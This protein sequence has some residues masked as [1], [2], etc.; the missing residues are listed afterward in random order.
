MKIIG[1]GIS[2]IL[3]V[4]CLSI[5]TGC[6]DDEGLPYQ[7]E[8]LDPVIDL[9]NPSS[10]S[11]T[12]I[13]VTLFD[14]KGNPM[15]GGSMSFSLSSNAS[16]YLWDEKN[17]K[18]VK[19]LSV[20][21]SKGDIPEVWYQATNKPETVVV[22]AYCPGYPHDTVV[23]TTIR[24]VNGTFN[25]DFSYY[26][27][28]DTLQVVFSD[29]SGFN[30]AAGQTITRWTWVLTDVTTGTTIDTIVQTSLQ[31]FSYGFLTNAGHRCSATLTILGN[32]G[33]TDTTTAVF[34]VPDI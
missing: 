24:V 6:G 29:E 22:S 23:R 4:M 2:V 28:E 20:D 7:I 19:S 10:P 32:D 12:F 16:G 33:A 18:A 14:T 11:G 13:A 5:L 9:S 30:D 31:P 15:T 25:A 21:I 1:K 27:D 17:E 34:D 8:A 26:I 3:F